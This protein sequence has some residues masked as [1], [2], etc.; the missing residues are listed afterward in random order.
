[1]QHKQLSTHIL[2]QPK[3][4]AMPFLSYC[5]LLLLPAILFLTTLICPDAKGQSLQGITEQKG[6]P[7]LERVPKGAF[8]L[9][10]NKKS[11]VSIYT[12][13]YGIFG[14]NV[15]RSLSGVD[16]PRGEGKTY[17]FGGGFWFGAQKTIND[18][19]RKMSVVSYNANS[20][21]SWFVPGYINQ[22]LAQQSTDE[23]VTGINNNRAYSSVDY[24]PSTGMPIDP[25]DI[26][27]PNW[28]IWKT[29]T[30]D[31]RQYHHYF[32][33]VVVATDQRN[34]T[35]FPAGPAFNSDEDIVAVYRDNDLG[36]YEIGQ[37]LA[38]SKGY[39]IGLQVEQ[40]IHSWESGLEKD[41]L[42][43]RY[44]IINKSGGELRDCYIAPVYDLDIATPSNDHLTMAIASPLEDTLHLAVGWTEKEPNRQY[45]YIGI[46]LLESP[47]IDRSTGFLRK[48]K[49]FYRQEE[50]LGVTSA[51]SWTTDTDPKTPEQRYDLMATKDHRL[52]GTQPGDKRLMLASGPFTMRANDTARITVGIAFAAAKGTTANGTWEDM[53]N[54]IDLDLYMQK[55]WNN[56]MMLPSISYIDIENI[57]TTAPVFRSLGSF[58]NPVTGTSATTVAFQLPAATTVECILYSPIGERI[59][60]Q[61]AEFQPGIHSFMVDCSQFASGSY[62]YMIKTSQE[63]DKGI[64]TVCR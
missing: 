34:S 43:L 29:S 18:T 33:S 26:S 49:P 14:L 2:Q 44:L 16:W 52:T 13:N 17:I 50:Q 57:N 42:I 51:P 36:Q 61:E 15:D 46:D 63:S 38:K 35:Q 45:G 20:G 53:Q 10:R 1:M 12:T 56:G 41:F 64:I 58:P 60:S 54:L 4:A 40:T 37:G 39:P 55:F 24:D 31:D 47:T 25:A 19:L 27:G 8:D 30:E 7:E 23:A 62:T 22:P 59:Y 5:R 21:V 6:E 9:L 11:N 28:P 3:T 32:G 48:D